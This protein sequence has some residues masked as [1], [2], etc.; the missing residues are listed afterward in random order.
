MNK[1]YKYLFS[2][3][4]GCCCISVQAQNVFT[5]TGKVMRPDS[6]PASNADVLLQSTGYFTTTNAQGVFKL[7][8]VVSA[9]Y[10]LVIATPDHFIY[11]DSIRVTKNLYLEMMVDT[12]KVEEPTVLI[13]ANRTN[14]GV[15]RLEDVEGTAIYAGKKNEIINISEVTGNTATNNTRQVYGKIVGLNIFENDGGGLQLGIGGRGL[16]PNRVSNF[17]TRQNG[18]DISADA[19]GY[20]ESYYTPPIDALERIEIVRGAASLQYG[21]QFGG[22]INFKFKQPIPDKKIQV[23]TKNTVGSFGL[24]NTFNSVAGTSGKFSYYAYGQYKHQNGW[25]PNSAFN[26]GAAY[27]SLKYQWNKKLSTTLEYT[28]QYYLT[29]QAGGLTDKQFYTDP[30]QS[31]RDRN[32]FK[33][34]WNLIAFLMDYK[35]NS[36]T[37]FNVRV[38]GL[39]AGRDALGFLGNIDRADPLQNRDLLSDKYRNYGMETRLL[40]HYKIVGKNATFLVGN[41]FYHGTT[42]RKQ[43]EANDGYGADFYYI[44]PDSLEGSDY[45]FPSYNVALFTENIFYLNKRWS[46][47]PGVRWEYIHTASEGY[48]TNI[49]KDLAGNVILYER[50][51]D[52]RS[53]GRSFVLFGMGTSYKLNNDIKLYANISQNYRSIN[54]NDMR[55]NNPNLV[56]DPNLRDERGFSSDIG[57]R[58]KWK[59]ILDFDANIFF[60]QY[61]NRIGT[62]FARNPQNLVYRFRTNVSDSRNLGVEMFMELDFAKL[63]NKESLTRFS[64]FNNIALIDAVY[65]SSDESAYRGNK[66]EYVPTLNYRSGLTYKYKTWRTILQMNYLSQQYSDATNTEAVVP[67]AVVGIIPSYTVWDWSIEYS[68]KNITAVTGV[69]NLMNTMYFTRRAE[70]YPGP[71]ILPSD[72]RSLFLTLQLTF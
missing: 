54:F 71:G 26:L 58:G 10:L 68:Y 33:V 13:E 43:G 5:I 16:N 28:F 9:T 23:V 39:V 11:K 38:F 2:F 32:W 19:L 46:L 67:N 62:V 65:I 21:T 20:P 25:R 66:V 24:Y 57:I 70:G 63:F 47:T 40:H 51:E 42:L 59:N 60:M 49:Q 29:Q 44:N 45:K 3:I 8:N 4:V 72:G 17:N 55:V 27:V 1:I 30:R 69:N 61:K 35:F 36:N 14:L 31:I 37:L 34:N 48:Y 18:Y 53:R 64:W 52:T 7:H 12:M 56:V 41:R 6:L 50:I 22:F 15:A